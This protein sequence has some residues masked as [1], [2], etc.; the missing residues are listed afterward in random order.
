MESRVEQA[1]AL[2]QKGYNCAQ[3]IICTYC[4]LFGVDEQTA[5]KMSEGFGLGMG[6]METCGAL[7]G[8]LMM[9]GLKTAQA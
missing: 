9:A 6:M 1:V 8:G 4:D 2:H 3:A 5:Y 7:T